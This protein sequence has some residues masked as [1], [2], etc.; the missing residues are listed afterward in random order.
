MGLGGSSVA[1]SEIA[2][3]GNDEES[4][5]H[6]EEGHS[7]VAGNVGNDEESASHS[8]EGHSEVA[9]NVGN[10]DYK[11]GSVAAS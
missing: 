11:D 8:E 7:E 3:V 9:G 10:G 1:A 5:S 4:A 2:D 6:L